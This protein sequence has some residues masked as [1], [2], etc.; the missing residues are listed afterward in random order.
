MRIATI[1]IIEILHKFQS[2]GR[3]LTHPLKWDSVSLDK[4]LQAYNFNISR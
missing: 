2:Q 4:Q 3:K 1:E